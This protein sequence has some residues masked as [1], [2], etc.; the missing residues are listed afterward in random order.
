MQYNLL[1]YSVYAMGY[2]SFVTLTVRH[3]SGSERDEVGGAKGVVSAI[4]VTSHPLTEI[5]RKG[6]INTQSTQTDFDKT[7]LILCREYTF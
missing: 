7:K 3:C 6:M 2:L 4:A 5:H 1:A